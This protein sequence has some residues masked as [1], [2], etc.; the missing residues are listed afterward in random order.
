[1]IIRSRFLQTGHQR[2]IE[3]AYIE[4]DDNLIVGFGEA[5]SA[6]RRADEDFGDAV[7]L[8]GFINAHTHLELTH[9]HKLVQPSPDFT[10]WLWRL[11]TH[12][13]ANPLDE[14][15]VA[16]SVREGI[17]QTLAAGV[18]AIGD[19]SR[20]PSLSRPQ[21]VASPLYGVSFGEVIAIGKGRSLLAPKVTAA[22][23]R[24][25]EPDRIV[26]GISPHAPY[27]IEPDGIRLCVAVA[28]EQGSRMCMHLLET[29]EETDFTTK[30][31]GV[32]VD[33][34]QRLGVWDDDVPQAGH[35]PFGLA[36]SCG[37]LGPRCVLAHMNYV[38]DD[39]MTALAGAGASVAYCPQTHAAFEHPPHRFRDMLAAGINVCIGTDSL[40]TN[41]TLSVM[42]E[43]RFL[44][45]RY[46][47][48]EVDLLLQLGTTNG[49]RALGLDDRFGF[50]DTGRPAHL[51]VFPVDAES[52]SWEACFQSNYGARAT[53]IDGAR[54]H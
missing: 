7:I 2:C 4:I 36:V 42:D 38:T 50:L 54:V 51:A 46:P 14:K 18:V 11:V 30:R 19:I 32:F 24:S 15:R 10:D 31:T 25:A 8:P 41:P 13:R 33:Y 12:F 47:D 16:D 26:A 23:N 28:A 3:N 21:L 35:T 45:Q 9:L 6:P 39:E 22:A 52:G 27:T 1:M 48:V 53:Y 34:L 49:A 44:H 17:R 5:A 29:A 43:L 40:A 37:L 20:G